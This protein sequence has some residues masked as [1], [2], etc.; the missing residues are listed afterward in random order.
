MEQSEIYRQFLPEELEPLERASKAMAQLAMPKL[1]EALQKQSHQ[2]VAFAN[3]SLPVAKLTV[4]HQKWLAQELE[5]VG[6]KQSPA[7]KD[8]WGFIQ[9][10]LEGLLFKNSWDVGF[11]V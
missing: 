2:I 3:E 4:E 10:Y 5:K 11:A 9:S 7:I 8:G 6:S 1:Q